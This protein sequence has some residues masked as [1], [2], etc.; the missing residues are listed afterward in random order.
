MGAEQLARARDSGQ[1]REEHAE[2][3]TSGPIATLDSDAVYF[4]DGRSEAAIDAPGG[5]LRY[6]DEE[7]LGTAQYPNI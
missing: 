2:K 4:N 6:P 7:R 5:G 3:T 1:L